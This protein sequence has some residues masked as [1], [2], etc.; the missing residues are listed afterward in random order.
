MVDALWALHGFLHSESCPAAARHQHGPEHGCRVR[1]RRAS[2]D[3]TFCGTDIIDAHA[4]QQRTAAHPLP[5]LEMP[6]KRQCMVVLR[7]ALRLD[8]V[9]PDF[10][11]SSKAPWDPPLAPAGFEQVQNLSAAGDEPAAALSMLCNTFSCRLGKSRGSYKPL[12]SIP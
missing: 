6:P 11:G 8:E 7:H 9:D 3:K 1:R 10:A 5:L 12:R 2:E 4:C